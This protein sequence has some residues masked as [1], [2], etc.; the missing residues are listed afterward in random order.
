MPDGPEP[1]PAAA[2]SLRALTDF[3]D[4]IPPVLV[5]ELRQGLRG[6]M[7]VIPFLVLQLLLMF[8]NTSTGAGATASFWHFI[9]ITL[10][11]LL[12]SRSLGALG[13]ERDAN[14]LDTLVLTRLT[15]W[16]IVWGKWCAA[17]AQSA[18]VTVAVVPHLLVRYLNG[19]TSF[20]EEG[21]V[22]IM[23]LFVS[24]GVAGVFT[25]ASVIKSPLLRNAFAAAVM[26]GVYVW[27]CGPVIY[28][29][30]RGADGFSMVV[31]GEVSVLSVWAALFSMWHA[32]AAIAPAA[33]SVTTARRLTSFL[34]VLVF[35]GLTQLPGGGAVGLSA[36]GLFV[37]L[38]AVSVV[39]MGEPLSPFP[40]GG[41]RFK[42]FGG[43][44]KLMG[45]VL[46][47]GW[48]RGVLFCVGMWSAASLVAENSDLL[49]A[50]PLFFL[51]VPARLLFPARMRMGT[52]PMILLA[53]TSQVLLVLLASVD[54]SQ[55]FLM[56][57]PGF[58]GRSLWTAD[59][60]WMQTIIWCG[61]ACVLATF[62][63]LAQ[64]RRMKEH[65]VLRSSA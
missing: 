31:V 10:V 12:P 37:M 34:A 57:I 24:G 7:F 18:L 61:L 15:P 29:M 26:I 4:R 51:P 16:R 8:T 62:S 58:S 32:A 17:A 38:A 55:T 45:I 6:R 42:H 20:I 40:F 54:S 3:S 5:K 36:Y 63:Q 52:A 49:R 28:G 11:F 56:V 13:E 2:V 14:T 43:T 47:P 33:Q 64:A 35:A 46:G 1:A 44:G 50:A 65:A 48:N 19:G 9:L 25:A 22:L 23:F 59:T 39:E 53:A 60:L 30:T 41:L 21:F 27:V